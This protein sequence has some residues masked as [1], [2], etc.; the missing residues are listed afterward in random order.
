[1]SGSKR[2]LAKALLGLVLV[3]LSVLAL[4]YLP[5]IIAAS[6]LLV[7]LVILLSMVGGRIR[8]RRD[9]RDKLLAD[10]AQRGD[11]AFFVDPRD[12]RF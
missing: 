8:H 5:L 3:V 10:A 9:R 1:M 6:I 12:H 11:S 4:Y 2:P 7:V